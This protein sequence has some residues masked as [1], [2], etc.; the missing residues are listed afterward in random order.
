[1]MGWQQFKR[2]TRADFLAQLDTLAPQLASC[3]RWSEMPPHLDAAIPVLAPTL[4]MALCAVESRIPDEQS[5]RP[6]IKELLGLDRLSRTASPVCDLPEY[7]AMV[8]HHMLGAFYVSLGLSER[9]IDLLRHTYPHP[10]RQTQERLINIGPAMGYSR[11][12]DSDC[13]KGWAW[14]VACWNKMPWL[15]SFFASR[16]DWKDSLSA[17]HLLAS[18]VEFACIVGARNRD[19][20]ECRSSTPL[21]FMTG[22]YDQ[23]VGLL[24]RALPSGDTVGHLASATGSDEGDI[25]RAWPQWVNIMLSTRAAYH[26][27]VYTWNTFRCENAP[28]L[29]PQ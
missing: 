15:T 16:Q 4:I 28:P 24:N 21:V 6:L 8:G 20:S 14:L 23:F 3:T 19:M 10:V 2:S 27:G 7:L 5:Q 9:A 18:L 25:R 11:L 17:Y 13:T 29:L 22:D 26:D 1:M 12:F